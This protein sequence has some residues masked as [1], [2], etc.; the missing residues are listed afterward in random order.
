MKPR[1]FEYDDYPRGKDWLITVLDRWKYVFEDFKATIFCIPSEMTAQ[2]FKPLVDRAD[3]IEIG[4]HGFNHKKGAWRDDDSI[5]K[6]L[7]VLDECVADDR[8]APIFKAPWYGYNERMIKE[9]ADRKL[10]V[11]A[12]N[13][14][15]FPYPAD[16][17]TKIWDRI[18]NQIGARSCAHLLAHPWSRKG[19]SVRDG[20][21]TDVRVKKWQSAWDPDDK[22]QL[23]SKMACSSQLK[24]NLGCENQIWDGW[25]CLDNK[26]RSDAVIQYEF[27]SQIPFGDNM[28]DLI[29]TSHT[30]QHMPE[31][32]YV[33][34]F[35]ECWRVLRP[36]GVLRIHQ[37]DADGGYIWRAIGKKPP[38]GEIKSEPSKSAIVAAAEKVGFLV[39]ESA[40][41]ETLSPHKDVLQGDNRSTLYNRGFKFYIE[42]VKNVEVVDPRKSRRR[43]RYTLPAKETPVENPHAEKESQE[44]RPGTEAG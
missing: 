25:K 12:N 21:L 30:M 11:A 13:L 17:Q 19:A 43:G 31:S 7:P 44:E 2:A 36:H 39:S 9:L 24:I 41:G 18:G 6:H 1:T 42:C 26:P 16:P 29:L 28:S 27:E 32:Y 35:L 5:E 37:D 34:F 38:V 8:Y 10:V 14:L 4:I 22:W 3:F 23:A 33:T 40:P 15:F 20:H